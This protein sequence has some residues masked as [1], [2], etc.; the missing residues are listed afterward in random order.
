MNKFKTLVTVMSALAVAGSAMSAVGA[1][2]A[3]Q[4]F[5]NA[6]KAPYNTHGRFPYAV[7]PIKPVQ[8][9]VANFVINSAR[10]TVQDKVLINEFAKSFKAYAPNTMVHVN[11]F[12]S[13][14]GPAAFNAKLSKARAASVKAYLVK[15]GVP[16]A[17]IEVHGYGPSQPMASNKT[18]DGRYMNQRV[19]VVYRPAREEK[20][21]TAFPYS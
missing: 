5:M 12:T 13:N 14:T 9:V 6:D 10:L 19:E 7:A 20:R 2:S 15:Q 11:G 16:V 18:H 1:D 8:R 4:S 17:Q 3:W 21:N